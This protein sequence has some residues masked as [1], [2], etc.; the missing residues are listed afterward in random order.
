M[1]DSALP[2]ADALRL[3]LKAAEAVADTGDGGS[4]NLDSAFLFARRGMT[5][6]RFEESALAAGVGAYRSH[7]RFW[8][9]WFLE[10][11]WGQGARRTQ[12]AEA[13]VA[14]LKEA[15]WDACVYYVLD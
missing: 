12:M 8:R 10:V 4:A 14:T 5:A 6:R 9:G 7:H 11:Q 2:L 15:G 3:A 13:A 1:T